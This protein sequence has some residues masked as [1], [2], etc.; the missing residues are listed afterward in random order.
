MKIPWIFRDNEP[1]HPDTIR[2]IVGRV[3]EVNLIK[4]FGNFCYSFGGK[5]YHQ[6][7]GG[8]T[9]TNMKLV[10]QVAH[11]AAFPVAAVGRLV[12]VN[13]WEWCESA[14]IVVISIERRL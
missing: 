6:H 2:M 9:G 8:P 5:I 4:I 10:G 1:T 13:G 11:M 12:L 7:T 3:L 14:H